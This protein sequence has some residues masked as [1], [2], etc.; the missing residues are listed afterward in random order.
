VVLG[1]PERPGAGLDRVAHLI[2]AGLVLQLGQLVGGLGLEVGAGGVDEDDVQVQVEQVRHGGEH[3]RGDLGQRVEQEVHRPV[4][5]IIGEPGQALDR[6]P[7]G[8]PA[9]RRQLAARLQR[10]LR[11]QGE[12]HPLGRLAVQSPP[13]GGPADRRPDAQP[14]PDPVQR[15]RSAQPSGEERSL[16]EG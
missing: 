10:P 12:E 14:L 7:V 16:Q 4:R 8:D 3:L 13:L 11:D 9:G 15:P 6:H 5:L 2:V 1:V